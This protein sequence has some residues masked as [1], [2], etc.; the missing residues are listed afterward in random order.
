[1]PGTAFFAKFGGCIR[2]MWGMA[3]IRDK[4]GHLGLRH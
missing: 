4:I 1:M 2:F 3:T